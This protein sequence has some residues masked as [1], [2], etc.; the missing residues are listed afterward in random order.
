MQ[1]HTDEGE[2]IPEND[3]VFEIYLI[4]N[5]TERGTHHG[6]AYR[7]AWGFTNANS[8]GKIHIYT[9]KHCVGAKIKY[10]NELI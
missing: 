10:R 7:I 2:H 6:Y 1:C 3:E 9:G 5:G 8:G 4:F